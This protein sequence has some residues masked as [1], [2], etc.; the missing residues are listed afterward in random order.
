MSEWPQ[1]DC[2]ELHAG[3]I[4]TVQRPPV[5]RRVP[6]AERQQ[7]CWSDSARLQNFSVRVKQ[8]WLFFLQRRKKEKQHS[9]GLSPA[10]NRLQFEAFQPATGIVRVG[11]LAGKS[12]SRAE[13]LSSSNVV[14][15]I[16]AGA[17]VVCRQQAAR[18]SRTF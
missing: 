6:T 16:V 3:L 4:D 7:K 18:Q 1:T 5:K 9:L 10:A 17:Y 14:L 15:A 8:T 13:K 12:T 11:V 2:C